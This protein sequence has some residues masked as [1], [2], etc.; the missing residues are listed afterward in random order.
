MKAVPC[1]NLRCDQRESLLRQ[2]LQPV[3]RQGV[4][5]ER[6]WYCSIE[7]LEGA[8]FPVIQRFWE[9]SEEEPLDIRKSRLGF[10]LVE[11]GI[12][13]EDQLEAVLRMQAQQGGSTGEWLTRLNFVS[14]RELTA[15][16]SQQLGFPWIGEIKP[17]LSGNLLDRLPKRL[18]VEFRMLPLE[19]KQTSGSLVIVTAASNPVS[20]VHMLRK[21][22]DCSVHA[23][24]ASD[25]NVEEGLREF[26][27]SHE[28]SSSEI[29]YFE[30]ARPREILEEVVSR[31]GTFAARELRIESLGESLWCRYVRRGHWA[32]LFIERSLEK[33]AE[34][35]GQELPTAIGGVE[36][37]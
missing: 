9:G 11:K 7:C 6:E 27:Q 30:T 10:I 22:L 1:S 33:F 35:I 23:F 12:I 21:M 5:W 18:Y 8:I 29:L 15:T 31:V 32:D 26:L 4:H 17:D 36:A 20:V 24:L 2:W 37:G 13:T 34:S 25:D 19:Y 14:S 3:V 28:D 16:L